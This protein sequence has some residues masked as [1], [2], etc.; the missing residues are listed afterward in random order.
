M[1]LKKASATL[2][3]LTEESCDIDAKE[4]SLARQTRLKQKLSQNRLATITNTRIKLR[5]LNLAI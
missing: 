5:V 1:G 3:A 4:D 2:R